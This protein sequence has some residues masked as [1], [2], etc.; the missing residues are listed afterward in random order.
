MTITPELAACYAEAE[1][2]EKAWTDA[3][4][5]AH[6]TAARE[7]R[8]SVVGRGKPGSAIRATYD[9]RKGALLRLFKAQDEAHAKGEV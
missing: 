6:G 5:A 2:A 4:I 3:L 1:A 7:V 8:Y 9:A